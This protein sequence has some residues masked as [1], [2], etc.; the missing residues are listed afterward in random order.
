VLGADI[1]AAE[2]ESHER[3]VGGV[4]LHR[5]TLTQ[6]ER[7]L[8]LGTASEGLAGPYIKR[9]G[10]HGGSYRHLPQCGLDRWLTS[11]TN[12]SRPFRVWGHLGRGKGCRGL[13]S[14]RPFAF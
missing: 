3:S 11:P 12:N 6:S 1:F 5:T 9:Q 13:A 4:R 8:T 10:T 14:L 2:L 7:R